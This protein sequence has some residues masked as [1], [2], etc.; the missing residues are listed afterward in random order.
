MRKKMQ[1]GA[2]VVTIGIVV[3][4]YQ[5]WELS[6]RCMESVQKACG[7]FR[8]R[9]YLVDNASKRAMPSK[10]QCF[11]TKEGTRACFLKADE[12]RGYASGNNLGI[13]RALEDGCG[14]IVVANNDI[15]FKSGAIEAMAVCL[16]RHPKAGIVGPMVVGR[17]G[18]IQ[19]SCCSMR[20]GM[21]EIFQIYTVAK[22]MFPRK[23]AVYYC[24]NRNP[25]KRAYVYHVSG[26]C[27]AM[28][29]ACAK[30]VT[31]L[32]EGTMLYGEELILGLTMERCGY[33]TI[34][35]PQ[36]VVMHWHGATAG[37]LAPLMYQCISQSELY[38]CGKYLKA[39]RWQLWVLYQYRRCLY[40]LRC[41]KSRELARSRSTF[42]AETKKS[43]Q[44]ARNDRKQKNRT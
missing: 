29:A 13:A 14:V 22:K 40:L 36:S 23:R 16:L 38:Y 18:S 25:Y 5:T 10:M 24:Q 12:N 39:A 44:Q 33:R 11:L 27:F 35:E 21:W 19:Q 3:L 34:Y 26:C 32:D 8:W 17:D 20:T 43:Y 41:M 31:P 28:S 2:A 4:N 37:R 9:I 1:K 15:V 6:L 30:A 42:L 7:A